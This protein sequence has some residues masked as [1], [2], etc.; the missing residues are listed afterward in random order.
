MVRSARFAGEEDC[1]TAAADAP[2]RL[3]GV[4]T[5]TALEKPY[6]RL[7]AP[8]QASTVRPPAIL[9]E[10][11][12]VVKRNWRAAPN[13]DWAW[14]VRRSAAASCSHASLPRS[15]QLKSIRQ[16]LTV[17]HCLSPLAVDVYETHGRVALEAADTAQF[18]QCASVLRALHAA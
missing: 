2:L 14:C 8:P 16:D 17:Q 4:G 6:L 12:A 15:E 5:S 7:T 3:V 1:A 11:L 10:S 13:Y 18:L 9:R